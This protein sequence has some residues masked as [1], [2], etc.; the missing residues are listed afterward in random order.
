MKSTT[1]RPVG[2]MAA[3]VLLAVVGGLAKRDYDV[4]KRL[5]ALTKQVASLD[6]AVHDSRGSESSAT[7]VSAMCTYSSLEVEAIARSV[8]ALLP[9]AGASRGRSAS[10]SSGNTA[11]SEPPRTL[12]QEQALAQ[13]QSTVD[14]VL[15][16]RSISAQEATQIRQQLQASGSPEEALKLRLSII[17]A[18]NRGELVPDGPHAI[19]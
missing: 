9:N 2:W 6:T 12:D 7:S 4:Q 15:R 14:T 19:P 1:S 18:I 8:A 5:E 3:A 16:R 10:A 13:A 11:N 17:Q